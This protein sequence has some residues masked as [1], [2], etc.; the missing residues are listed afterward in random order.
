MSDEEESFIILGS[1]PT[2]SMNY[3]NLSILEIERKK[4]ES[5]TN[6]MNKMTISTQ[7]VN[8]SGNYS[9]LQNG[10]NE[11]KQDS[12]TATTSVGNQQPSY[13]EFKKSFN[14]KQQQIKESL[15][16]ANGFSHPN[17]NDSLSNSQNFIN[18]EVNIYSQFPSLMN[19]SH[20][21]NSEV[22][23]LQTLMK[24]NLQLKENL[25]KSNLQMRKNFV[26]MQ[27]WQNDVKVDR[28]KHLELIQESKKAIEELQ[29]T[30]KALIDEK[31][32][33]IEKQRFEIETVKMHLSDKL[34]ETEENL[35]VFRSSLHDAKTEN[36]ELTKKLSEKLS[37][38][39]NLA[40]KIEKLETETE[41]YVLC[42]ANQPSMVSIAPD[43]IQKVEHE[44]IVQRLKLENQDLKEQL[45]Q[46]GETRKE[47]ISSKVLI[48][49]L[50]N[51]I[52]ALNV[53]ISE[54]ADIKKDYIDQLNLLQIN[55]ASAEE[56]TK[57]TNSNLTKHQSVE[58]E[59]EK[60]LQDKE[61]EIKSLK[62]DYDVLNVQVDV[63]KNDFEAERKSREKIAGENDKLSMDLKLLQRRN[64][65]LIAEL[66]Q[67]RND[68][69]LA[70]VRAS[71]SSSSPPRQ[72]S[73]PERGNI[74]AE[75]SANVQQQPNENEQIYERPTLACPLCAKIYRD[76][77]SL[78]LH[79]A[80]C[81]GLPD[82][83]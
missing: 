36:D 61:V 33:L 82:T 4:S 80:D 58:K 26:E 21:S 49:N 59:L 44:E 60:K 68:S 57:L 78:S 9:L 24:E 34:R 54:F 12:I 83:I 16:V 27:K 67:T 14:E 39:Q 32:D 81:L 76:I 75:P 22:Q 18:G 17:K 7:T 69:N 8:N 10:S 72:R 11:N 66:Q 55:L 23:Q 19:G 45:A 74:M 38:I 6:S 53:Q 63:Y 42:K 2:E 62:N 1:T 20:T 71:T 56:L 30:N 73:T 51:Q 65:E 46:F 64:H 79:A 77:S 48:S 3:E 5:L 43:Y 41:G 50:E 70:N 37:I 35:N 40:F 15:V 52:S 29:S 13:E 25:Q 28:A 47:L 31:S